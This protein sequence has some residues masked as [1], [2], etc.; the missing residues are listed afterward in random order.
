MPLEEKWKEEEEEEEEEMRKDLQTPCFTYDGRRS[1]IQRI[2]T[3]NMFNIAFLHSG[4]S[5]A[6]TMAMAG[7]VF[8]YCIVL[9]NM[10]FLTF[11]NP[12]K[13]GNK[14]NKKHRRK[15]WL[16]DDGSWNLY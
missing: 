3:S 4:S 14:K 2:T 5:V 6:S 11:Q 15:K 7:D 16:D 10:L 8:S 12:K 9:I 13:K 1:N